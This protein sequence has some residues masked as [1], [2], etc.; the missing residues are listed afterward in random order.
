M[1]LLHEFRL[2]HKAPEAVNNVCSTM[3][4]N[5]LSIRTAQHGFNRFKNGNFE[6]DDLP[7]SSRP[8]E[9]D[10]DL[11]RQLIQQDP[12]F[13]LQCLAEQLGCSYVAVGKHLNKDMETWSSDTPRVITTSA[14]TSV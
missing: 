13:T 11:L 3:S 2:G 10:V 14:T 5:V 12:R 4:E 8:V 1:L 6:L 7:R 9:A